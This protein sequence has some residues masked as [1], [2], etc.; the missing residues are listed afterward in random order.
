MLCVS[1]QISSEDSLSTFEAMLKSV[2]FAD[3]LIIFNMERVD[4]EALDLFAKYKAKVINIKTPQVVEEIRD[5]QV[6]EA[7]EDWVLIMDYDE[8]IK[9]SLQNEILAIIGNKASCPAYSIGRDNFSLGYPLKHGGWEKDYVVRLVQKSRFIKWPTD[10]HS[11]PVVKGLIIKTTNSMEHHK[12]AS[13]EQ[14]VKKTNRYSD[15]EARQFLVGGMKKVTQLTILRK[16]AMEFIRRY[17]FKKGFL[18][19]SIGLFQSLY[20]GYSVFISYSKLYAL[21]NQ[22]IIL[23][24]D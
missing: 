13:L 21:Q 20:Q 17:F 5:R 10:I 14:M 12:D 23:K 19:G 2:S 4:T 24:T 22:K 7:K 3:E 16:S 9:E 1:T 15:I 18:D 8:I 11:T 6:K